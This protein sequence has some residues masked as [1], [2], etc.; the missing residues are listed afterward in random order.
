M[1][2][3]GGAVGGEAVVGRGAVG[4]EGLVIRRVGKMGGDVGGG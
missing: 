2:W 3:E 1:W 4:G